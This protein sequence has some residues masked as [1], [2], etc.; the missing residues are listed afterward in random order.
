MNWDNWFV[1]KKELITDDKVLAFIKSI[2]VKTSLSLTFILSLIVLAILERPTPNWEDNCSPTVLT[3]LLE[4]W[5]ISSISALELINS[6]RYLMIV[7]ISSF[8]KTSISMSISRPNFLFILYLPTSPKLY[9]WS[10]KNN[11]SIIPLAVSSS[12]GS[13]FLS[14]L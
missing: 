9:L 8:V 14:C 7:I 2:G 5:S 6:I 11:L 3:L 1:P 13:A 10:E 12:G 4:R